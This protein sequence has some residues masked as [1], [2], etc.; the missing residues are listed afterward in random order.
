LRDKRRVRIAPSILSA[1]FAR[2][3]E[4]VREAASAGADCFHLDVMDG[5]FVP[6]FSFG[7][8][9]VKAIRPFT[10]LPFHTHLMVAQPDK[11][12]D[13]F[14]DAGADSLTVH[15]EACPDLAG[16]V[17][18][19]K[20]AG[21]MAGVTLNPETP[22]SEVEAVLS[23]AGHLLIM[24]VN[25]GFGGQTLIPETVEKVRQARRMLDER[26]LDTEIVVDGGVNAKTAPSLV[27]AGATLL[28]AG[29]AVFDK[30]KPVADALGRLRASVESVER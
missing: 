1:D 7:P 12:I 23:H 6:N 19:I 9:V 28:V 15:V 8:M 14:A 17:Q 27:S 26:G 21:M 20:A 5:V 30:K 24:L 29:S 16:T 18:R 22:L 2:L 4:Q 25:P 3:G 13:A 10:D 11:W